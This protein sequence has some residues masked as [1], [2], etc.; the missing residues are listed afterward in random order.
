MVN[1]LQLGH[2]FQSTCNTAC[3]GF[4]P[5]QSMITTLMCHCVYTYGL[6]IFLVEQQDQGTL[7][8]MSGQFNTGLSVARSVRVATSTESY[9]WSNHHCLLHVDRK[10]EVTEMTPIDRAERRLFKHHKLARV[11]QFKHKN[12]FLPYYYC[13]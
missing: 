1:V 3:Q 13:L 7:I 2:W 10:M 8:T 5:D 12:W 6:P 11:L 9:L 4:G